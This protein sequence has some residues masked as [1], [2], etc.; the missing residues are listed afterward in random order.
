[1]PIPFYFMHVDLWVPG[2]DLSKNSLGS[3][4]LNA[5]CDLKQF[6]V[7][8]MTMETHAEHLAQFFMDNVV[9]SMDMFVILVVTTNSRFKN[10]FKDMCAALGIIY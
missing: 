2:T 4:L 6:F 3:R 10:V 7:S 8:T 1:M 5:V 9:L